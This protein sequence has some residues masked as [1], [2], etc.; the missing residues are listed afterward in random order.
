MTS[1]KC[2]IIFLMVLRFCRFWRNVWR[3]Q[4]RRKWI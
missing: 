2:I 4:S 3:Y 1:T